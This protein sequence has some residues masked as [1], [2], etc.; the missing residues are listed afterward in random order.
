MRKLVAGFAASLDGYIEDPNGAYEWILIDPAIDFA[1]W[2]KRFDTYFYG[3]RSYQVV[4][5]MQAFIS[6]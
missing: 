1:A 5:A 4:Q 6:P 3:R 2:A